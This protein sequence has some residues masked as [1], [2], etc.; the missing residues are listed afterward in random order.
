MVDGDVEESLYLVG[1]EVH[2]D[3]PVGSGGLYHVGNHLGGDGDMG[4]VF[5]VLA[6]ESVV[7]DDGHDFLCRGAL[8][9][10]NHQQQLKEVVGRGD[11][12][13]DDEDGATAD[14]VLIRG[15]KFAVGILENGGIA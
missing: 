6:G 11:G 5:A 13:L 9:G 1:M 4:F 10:V 14:G 12:G 15:L 7:G 8:G 2:A 3:D